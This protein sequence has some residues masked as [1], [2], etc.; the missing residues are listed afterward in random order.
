MGEFPIR[1][2]DSSSVVAG[3]SDLV[4]PPD[5]LTLDVTD[6][7]ALS[8]AGREIRESIIAATL[9]EEVSTAVREAYAAMCRDSGEASIDV[10]VRRCMASLFTDRAIVYRSQQGI[11]NQGVELSVGVQRLAEPN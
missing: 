7:Q 1:A 5:Q 11:P 10:A 2:S 9:P 3:A 6:T 4:V 8:A